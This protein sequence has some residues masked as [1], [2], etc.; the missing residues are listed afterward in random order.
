LRFDI[1]RLMDF[2]LL[3]KSDLLYQQKTLKNYNNDALQ[4]T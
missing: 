4:E 3:A 1:E 2:N